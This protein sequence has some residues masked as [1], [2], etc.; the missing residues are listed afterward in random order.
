MRLI[1]FTAIILFCTCTELKAQT[2]Y[3][4]WTEG[5]WIKRAHSDSTNSEQLIR[6]SSVDIAELVLD[7]GSGWVYWMDYAVEISPTQLKRARLDGTDL[8]RGIITNLGDVRALA[9]DSVA[10]KLYWA[11]HNNPSR[12]DAV[13]KIQR[14]NLDGSSIEDLIIVER[15][16]FFHGLALDMQRKEMYWTE[17]DFDLD[18]S[19]IW[20]A[21]LDGSN[22][23]QIIQ[24]RIM[25]YPVH[26]QLDHR[27]EKI[28]WADRERKTIQRANLDGSGFEVIIGSDH[29]PYN[30]ALD[31]GAGHLYWND[32]GPN[33]G[34]FDSVLKRANLDGTDIVEIMPI[35]GWDFV[36]LTQPLEEEIPGAFYVS[37]AFPNPFRT[38]TTIPY[39]VSESGFVQV[40]LYDVLGQEVG[41]LTAGFMPVGRHEVVWDGFDSPAG[42]YFLRITTEGQGSQV[43]TIVKVN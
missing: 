35:S 11:T 25:R 2:K 41:L 39:T 6:I 19:G 23:E 40:A 37:E 33:D 5:G 3:I 31:T 13:R 24:Q 29:N 28:Y 42:L 21:G 12:A 7:A 8:Q 34:F 9:L 26:I 15:Q 30:L 20:R 1:I 36:L 18:T 38:K 43:R 27:E 32:L 22:A 4:Y 16:G 17:I 14:A 10:G